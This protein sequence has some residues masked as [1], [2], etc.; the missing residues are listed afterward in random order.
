MWREDPNKRVIP[1]ATIKKMTMEELAER[2]KKRLCFHCNEMYDSRHRC[3][4]NFLIEAKWEDDDEDVEME[5]K[6]VNEETAP[7]ISLHAM[8]GSKDQ[9]R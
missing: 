2:R 4:K 6:D 1:T 5:I 3:Q 8:L 9:G 7:A